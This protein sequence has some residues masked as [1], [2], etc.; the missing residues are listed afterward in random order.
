M[1]N[2]EYKAN[3]DLAATPRRRVS[4]GAAK[5]PAQSYF[6]VADLMLVIFA[7][8]LT[9]IF[10][11]KGVELWAAVEQ[12]VSHFRAAIEARSSVG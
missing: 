7:L 9:A 5:L 3:Q 12:W 2:S 8:C 4:P 10:I 11:F 1:R 6:R